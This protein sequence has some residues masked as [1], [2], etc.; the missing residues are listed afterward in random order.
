[1]V[2]TQFVKYLPVKEPH[3]I[4]CMFTGRLVRC[5]LN[6]SAGIYFSC[7]GRLIHLHAGIFD[8]IPT[9]LNVDEN[10]W[11]GPPLT[12]P[13]HF[14]SHN[15]NTMVSVFFQKQ[16]TRTRRTKVVVQ[17]KGRCATDTW[18]STCSVTGLTT[19]WPG[20][21]TLCI[22]LPFTDAWAISAV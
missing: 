22:V 19:T 18:T 11:I 2:E 12:A 15:T 17:R 21:L 16:A 6:I 20:Q 7:L 3:Y 8:E 13:T 9:I 1:M 10:C 5:K 14:G 4:F